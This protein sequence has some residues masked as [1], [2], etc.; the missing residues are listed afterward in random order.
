VTNGTFPE[1]IAKWKT[2]PTQLY[3]SMV[4]PNEE[5]YQKF[6]RPKT[7]NLWKKYLKMLKIMPE[8]GKRTRTVLRMTLVKGHNDQDLEGYAKQIK[9]A[10]PHYVEVKSMVYVGGARST[11]RGLS[12]D[13]MLKNDDIFQIA[14]KLSEKTGYKIS[15]IHEPSRVV[16]LVRDEEAEK[17]RILQIDD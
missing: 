13:N 12:L 7:K 14:K 9:I 3:V 4:A 16:L 2:L 8:L 17:N 10:K 5:V 6:I 1:R 15:D 11:E